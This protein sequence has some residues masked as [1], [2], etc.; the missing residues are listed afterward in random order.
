MAT[1]LEYIWVD[2]GRDGGV[3]GMRSKTKVVTHAVETPEQAPD[4]TFDGSSTGQADGHD[5]DCILKPVF[6]CVDPTRGAPHKIV[7]CEVFD[8]KGN[9]HP[10]NTRAAL[11]AAA[12]K[13]KDQEPWFGIEQ[14]YTMFQNGRPLG[15]PDNGYPA[16]QGPFYCGVGADEVFGRPLADAHMDAC[17][18]AGLTFCGINAEVMPGQWEFQI[19]PSGPLEVGDHLMVARWLLYR[20]GEEFD[21][22]VTLDPKPVRGDWNG[23]GGHTNFSTKAM[24][25][26]GGIKAILAAMPKLEKRHEL[27]IANYGEG[28]ERRLTGKH[29]TCSYKEFR[30]GVANRGA[31]IRIPRHVDQQGNGY[32]EDRR[33]CANLDPY[34]VARLIIETIC[35]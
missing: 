9:P 27:H 17:I 2:G 30:F 20:V 18:D 10:T 33:P 1:K 7:L 26:P 32:L 3:Q 11:R 15:W 24:R 5:S 35:L 29:E 21:I 6:I 34:L 14:E 28:I 13:A 23:A 31:S 25:E 19:G 16:P 4:W 22:A 12:E 8:A